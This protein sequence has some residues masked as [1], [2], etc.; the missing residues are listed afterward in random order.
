MSYSLDRIPYNSCYTAFIY[1]KGGLL[2]FLEEKNNLER[3][4][5]SIENIIY[6]RPSAR[7]GLETRLFFQ[8][9]SPQNR[10]LRP[11]LKFSGLIVK[12][13]KIDVFFISKNSA[14]QLFIFFCIGVYLK[15]LSKS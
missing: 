15:P 5:R 6:N 12:K 7:R 11:Y 14:L 13:A 4:T 3:N 8:G 1:Y 2:Q 9:F 10:T